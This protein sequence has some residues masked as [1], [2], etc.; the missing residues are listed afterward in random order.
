M[1]YL[2]VGALTI[3]ASPAL[4]QTVTGVCAETGITPESVVIANLDAQSATVILGRVQSA[5]A[6]RESLSSQH[7]A[8]DAVAATITELSEL[9][10]NDADEDLQQ[11]YEAAVATL[12]ARQQQITALREGLF[13]LA[14][15]GFPAPKIQRITVWRQGSPYRV[16]RKFRA[17]ELEHNTWKAIERALRAERRAI[18]TGEDLDEEPAQLLADIRSDPAVVEAGIP[19]QANFEAMKLLFGQF[20]NSRTACR[21]PTMRVRS[22]A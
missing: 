20:E 10:L 12:A 15:D 5:V 13:D 3:A 21:V 1:Y 9:M 17:K 19:L 8:A 4:A 6:L 11:E 7:D 22:R 18:R 2:L 14:L 16:Q